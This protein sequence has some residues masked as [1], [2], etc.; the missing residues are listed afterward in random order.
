MNCDVC[1]VHDVDAVFENMEVMRAAVKAKRRRHSYEY[2][3]L[4]DQSEI[5]MSWTKFWSI[6]E[7]HNG[8]S[9]ARNRLHDERQCQ[10]IQCNRCQS[11]RQCQT[12]SMLLRSLQKCQ[13]GFHKRLA[14]GYVF[15]TL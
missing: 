10:S 15:G 13:T 5:S 1:K 2:E 11:Q 9:G 6:A 4:S 14:S 7:L 3:D 12:W 8:D